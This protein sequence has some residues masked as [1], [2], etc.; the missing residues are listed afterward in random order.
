MSHTI[1]TRWGE[2][3]QDL[4]SSSRCYFF[5]VSN[6]GI[7]SNIK[8]IDRKLITI[9]NWITLS[10]L[11]TRRENEVSY[12]VNYPIVLKMILISSGFGKKK[13]MLSIFL[14]LNEES[15]RIR[16]EGL[17]GFGLFDGRA[18]IDYEQS[19]LSLEELK[20]YINIEFTEQ[21]KCS[22]K[23]SRKVLY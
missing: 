4:N 17:D 21:A 23:G 6:T 12:N 22:I 15:S 18:T 11:S 3:H 8:D 1:R 5:A 2:N 7:Q 10:N 16:V 19:K 14:T 20:T 13:I 9:K